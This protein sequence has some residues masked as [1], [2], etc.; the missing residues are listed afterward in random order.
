MDA[1]I[2]N[3][4]QTLDDEPHEFLAVYWRVVVKG[5][6]GWIDAGDRLGMLEETVS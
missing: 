5:C 1:Q 6:A 4:S 3:V 2:A